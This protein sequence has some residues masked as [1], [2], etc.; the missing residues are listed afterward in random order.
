MKGP[1]LS[2]VFAGYDVKDHNTH[3]KERTTYISLGGVDVAVLKLNILEDGKKPRRFRASI[4]AQLGKNYT[5]ARYTTH[6]H[7]AITAEKEGR[8]L[9]MRVAKEVKELLDQLTL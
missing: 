9:Y 2:T 3:Y 4:T 6:V 1:R 7:A 8:A 5:V